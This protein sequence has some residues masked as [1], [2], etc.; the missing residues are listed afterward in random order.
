MVA[1]A[2]L[3]MRFVGGGLFEDSPNRGCAAGPVRVLDGALSKHC[4]LAISAR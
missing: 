4:C 3:K 1:L 2:R